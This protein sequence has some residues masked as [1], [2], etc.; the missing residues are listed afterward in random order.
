MQPLELP[1]NDWARLLLLLLMPMVT[2]MR[3]P[4][5]PRTL[6]ERVMAAPKA[7]LTFG[8]RIKPAG[9]HTVC[10]HHKG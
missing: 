4:V 3:R 8:A 6:G 1:F 5:W 9:P 2:V 10:G 7:Q